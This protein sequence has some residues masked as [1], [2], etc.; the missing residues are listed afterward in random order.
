MGVVVE[1]IYILTGVNMI[2]RLKLLDYLILRYDERARD[3]DKYSIREFGRSATKQ[4]RGETS[5]DQRRRSDLPWTT[6]IRECKYL[7][8]CISSISTY[9]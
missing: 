9:I 4:D 8:D 5:V 3:K 2:F 6:N 1:C 7:L